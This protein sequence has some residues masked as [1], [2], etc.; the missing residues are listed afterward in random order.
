MST[1]GSPINVIE[2]SNLVEL[3]I[4]IDDIRQRLM[5]INGRYICIRSRAHPTKPSIIVIDSVRRA[6]V[7]IPVD[8]PVDNVAIS[9]TGHLVAMRGIT[10]LCWPPI[11]SIIHPP[12]NRP[13]TDH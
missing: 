10:T 8:A 5:S 12:S 11:L 6:K 1:Q 9:C 4:S 13:P 7:V 3:G 2:L